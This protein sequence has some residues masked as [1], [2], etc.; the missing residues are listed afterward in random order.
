MCRDA[1]KRTI[2]DA[3]DFGDFHDIAEFM[4]TLEGLADPKVKCEVN[5]TMELGQS[6]EYF[7]NLK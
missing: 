4:G 6:F 2:R 1:V 3:S 5:D 7:T